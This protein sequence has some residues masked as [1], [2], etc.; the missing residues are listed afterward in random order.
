[1]NS[2]NRDRLTNCESQLPVTKG[3][4]SGGKAGLGV[5]GGRRHTSVLGMD[6]QQGPAVQHTS[7]AMS[8]VGMMCARGDLDHGTAGI[9]AT[10]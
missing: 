4:R 2:Q 1:M 10:P 8:W 3:A 9:N 6:G 5:W 7:S